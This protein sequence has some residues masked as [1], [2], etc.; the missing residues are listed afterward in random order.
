[1]VAE[2]LRVRPD[3]TVED[4]MELFPGL[5]QS[6]SPEEV[7]NYPDVLRPAGLPAS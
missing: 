6:L 4:A 3:L 2:I 7:A 1:V 5:D